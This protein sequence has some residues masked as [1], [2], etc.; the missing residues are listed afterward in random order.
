MKK[1]GK[2]IGD[3]KGKMDCI[4]RIIIDVKRGRKEGKEEGKK[5]RRIEGK[6]EDKKVGDLKGK[7]DIIISIIIIIIIIGIDVTR[8]ERKA[9]STGIKHCKYTPL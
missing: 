6:K 2:K 4:I 1:E 7:M 8:E 5:T 3:L 9:G